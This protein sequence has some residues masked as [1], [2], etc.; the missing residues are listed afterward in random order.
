MT[1]RQDESRQN[2]LQSEPLLII[3][4]TI[5]M[6]EFLPDKIMIEDYLAFF[7]ISRITLQDA[8]SKEFHLI[9]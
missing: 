4:R 7:L 9:I 1:S 6:A 2:A 8:Y 3:I 5:I